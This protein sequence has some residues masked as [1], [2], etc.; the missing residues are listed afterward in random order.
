[1]GPRPDVG[2]LRPILSLMTRILCEAGEGSWGS[3]CWVS[4]MG[5]LWLP[6][7]HSDPGLRALLGS[8]SSADAANGI[9]WPSL[10]PLHFCWGHVTHGF[11]H[12]GASPGLWSSVHGH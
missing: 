7:A 1:M 11:S 9:L 6:Q 5:V 4:G 8:P 2:P 12:S 3:F 10:Y